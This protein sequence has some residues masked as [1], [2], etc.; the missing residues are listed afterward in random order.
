MPL[1][2]PPDEGVRTHLAA[3]Q[4]GMPDK[5][6]SKLPQL[7]V[8]VERAGDVRARLVDLLLLPDYKN[9][10][11]EFILGTSA[12]GSGSSYPSYRTAT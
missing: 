6:S 8:D 2:F 4:A 11:L 9:I 1:V 5:C 3:A 12:T 10:V 7:L